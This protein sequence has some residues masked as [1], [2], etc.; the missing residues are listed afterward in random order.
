MGDEKDKALWGKG[1]MMHF[2]EGSG[3]FRHRDIILALVRALVAGEMVIV[4]MEAHRGAMPLEERDGSA[5]SK[6]W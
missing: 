4:S 6:A 2:W 1:N 3:Y 5:G